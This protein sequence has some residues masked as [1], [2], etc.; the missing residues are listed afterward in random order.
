MIKKVLFVL[1][2]GVQFAAAIEASGVKAIPSC[3]P[4][5]SAAP[6][7]KAIPSC[8]PCDSV[9]PAVKAIPSC[10]PCDSSR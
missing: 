5:D 7:V 1:A 6:V 9:A 8:F 2:L 10:F 4:C 3:F